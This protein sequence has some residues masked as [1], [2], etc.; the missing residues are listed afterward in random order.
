M[1]KKCKDCNKPIDEKYFVCYTCHQK[2]KGT[3]PAEPVE[4]DFPANIFEED[5]PLEQWARG[6]IWGD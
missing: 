6:E 2:R 3:N 5:D 1:S 4:S